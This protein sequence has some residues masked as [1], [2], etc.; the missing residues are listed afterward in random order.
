MND[1]HYASLNEVCARMKSG[2]LSALQVTE[3]MLERIGEV[4]ERLKS[5]VMVLSDEARAAAERLDKD[6]AEGK[7]LGAL[8]G[9]PIALKDLLFTRGIATASG[10]MVMRD[11]IPDEDATVVTRLK[12]AGAVFIGKTQLTEGAFGVHHPQVD[13]PKNPWNSDHWP[14]VSSSGSGVAVAAGLAFGALGTDTGGSI[15]FPSASCGLV[16][17]KPT[18]GR[19]S[20]FGA[21]ALAESLDHIGPMTRSVGDAARMLQVLAGQDPR[22]P[23]TL[24]DPVP[25]YAA[26]LAEGVPGMK[27]G[28]D[29][30]YVSAGVENEVVQTVRD[31]LNVFVQLGAE[32]VEVT[33]PASTATLVQGWGVTCGVECAHAH[34]AYYP[35][36]KSE[37]GPVL[38]GLIDLGLGVAQRDYDSLERVRSQFR[39]ELND[40]LGRVDVLIAPCMTEL[41]PRMDEMNSAARNSDARADFITFTAPF[42]YSGHPTITLPAGLATG[43][44]PKSFQLVGR[45]LGEPTLIHAGSAYERALDFHGHPID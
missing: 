11:H 1:L 28:V 13:P 39:D 24:A 3:T 35:E 9:V 22:D 7:P 2:E 42:N 6:R 8:H 36:R 16:G 45:A 5:Y 40:T 31:A 33:M 12:E 18:Y 21:F 29:W 37:Y 15:R 23:S 30:R 4:D 32:V 41:P 27:I 44:M 10:T 17:I 43:G 20:R 19:V 25:N 26:A 34:R 14:G 38:A